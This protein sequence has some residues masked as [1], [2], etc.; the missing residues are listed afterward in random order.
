MPYY[1][2]P[3][4]LCGGLYLRRA[5]GAEMLVRASSS[6]TAE[7]GG[8]PASRVRCAARFRA[9]CFQSKPEPAMPG[10]PAGPS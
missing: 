8:Q 1:Q 2:R 9:Q 7:A 10:Q 5:A 3:R 4:L 6:E